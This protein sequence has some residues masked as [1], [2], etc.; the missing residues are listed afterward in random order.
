[1]KPLP[2]GYL[3]T[4]ESPAREGIPDEVIRRTLPFMPP[5]LRA[6]VKVQRLT[7]MRPGEVF[8]MRVGEID[9]T[10][11]SELW[12]YRLHSHKTEKKTKQKK[13]V[14]LGKPEQELLLPYL[15]GKKPDAAVFSPRTAMVER[16]TEQR[17]NRKSKL[18]PSQEARDTER[19]AKPP[20]YQESYNKDSYRQAVGHAIAKG[21]KVLPDGE[22]IP[23][24]YPYPL[25]KNFP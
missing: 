13:V 1:V 22:K 18:T 11:D 4:F 3:G 8:N 20:Q 16:R 14:P 5:V 19:A 9:R 2:E 7:G 23:H 15:E 12:L 6:M 24:W 17:T 21:N 25:R 10:A